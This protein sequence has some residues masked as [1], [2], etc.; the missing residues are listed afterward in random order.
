MTVKRY[1][2]MEKQIPKTIILSIFILSTVLFGQNDSSI[3][4][5]YGSLQVQGNKIAN[6]NGDP[7]ALRG[8]SL[9]WSQWSEGSKY[10]NASC[11]QWLKDDWKCGVVRAA[12][13]VE[14]G[15]YLS[16]PESEKE[17]VISVV[18]ACINSG[19]YVIID[20]H[21]HNAHHHEMKAKEF[22]A[23]MAQLYG[24]YPNVIYEIYNE[25]LD[26]TS[27]AEEIKPYAIA[28][29]DTIRKV[30]P[31]NLIIVG[32]PAWSQNVDVASQDP[33][34]YD[35]VAYALHFYAGS[36]TQWLRNKAKNA[37]NNGIAL[38]ATEWGTCNYDAKGPVDS[39][40]TEAWW[41]FMDNNM[42]SWCNWSICD[43]EETAAALLPG[44]GS[45]GN[46]SES[47]ISESGRFVRE[48]IIDWY[49]NIYT[50]MAESGYKNVQHFS[51]FQNYPNPF[52]PVTV[53]SWQL[54][55]S[56]HVDLSIYNLL[57]Q[58]VCTLVSEKQEAGNHRVDWNAG[59][60]ASG[61]YIYQLRA[62]SYTEMRKMLL[63]K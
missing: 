42:I 52:N 43:K 23:E 47:D 55:V 12:M 24:D 5:L 14:Y 56:S 58:K 60:V 44:A 9:F 22:F 17:K 57:G 45:T 29:I 32:T 8:M 15:G 3:V 4:E 63:L 2:C 6:K 40:E 33:L 7:V 36:H 54:A 41:Q 53:I 50:G 61:V 49:E 18:D 20:W 26:T 39:G 62:G 25:P 35:N 21:D 10:Y 27:W 51:L 38:F 30:D 28:V 59:G 37:L 1:Q 31:D 11:I 13:A 34:A 19:I 46:W 48:E 16:H